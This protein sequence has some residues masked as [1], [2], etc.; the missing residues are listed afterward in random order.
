VIEGVVAAADAAQKIAGRLEGSTI[1]DVRL[2]QRLRADIPTRR[3]RVPARVAAVKVEI[4]EG[5]DQPALGKRVPL[6]TR[7]L[8][9]L[10]DEMGAGLRDGRQEKRAH[11]FARFVRSRLLPGD[12]FN[13]A[14]GSIRLRGWSS[15]PQVSNCRR[16]PTRTDAPTV[17][18]RVGAFKARLCPNPIR[19]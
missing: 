11:G 18:C 9:E 16:G 7:K 15:H 1:L 19:H 8:E 12:S 6:Q 10:R 5:F 4:L 17:L 13:V 2:P 3:L 14:R